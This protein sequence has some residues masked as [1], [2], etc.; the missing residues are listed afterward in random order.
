M[1]RLAVAMLMH[2]GNSFSPLVTG[3]AEFRAAVWCEGA[4]AAAA[5]RGTPSE[6]GGVLDFLSTRSDWQA[7]FLRLAHATPAGPLDA[8]LFDAICDEIVAGLAGQR[9]DAVYLALHGALMVEG[10]DLADLALIARVREAIGA[11][12]LFGVSFDLHANLDPAIVGHVDFASGYKTHPHVDQR[13]TAL[14]VL[15]ALDRTLAGEIRP[16]GHIAKA[17]TILPSINMRTDAGPMAELK[18]EAAALLG[19]AVLE[20]VPF[21][22]FSYADTAAAGAAAMVFADGDAHLAR[23]TAERLRDAIEARRDDFFQSLPDADRAIADALAAID[24]GQGPAAVVDAAD[25]PLSGGIL[26][27]PALLSALIRANP[28]V[29]SLMLLFCD[30]DLVDHAEAV[31]IGGMVAGTLGGRLS[32][33]YGAPVP[34]RATVIALSSGRFPARPPLLCGPWMDFGRLA[35]LEIEG[36]AIRV[37]VSSGS[38]SPHDPGLPEALG[39]DLTD[40]ALVCVKAKNHFRAAYDGR[41]GTIIA[42]D[43]PGP[44]A[45]DITGFAFVRAPGHLYPLSGRA[46]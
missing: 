34:I 25:N 21:G 38:A 19:G 26:D 27:T 22:G 6:I 24:A 43:A 14:R 1:A 4:E 9:F 17:D 23:R 8:G 32:A 2:E 31:G 29:P 45:L 44:A 18:A 7:E 5:Y 33:L 41:F 30:P 15:T 3:L 16:V 20:A 28:A 40:V 37:V 36:T 13:E 10:R 35:L 46:A 11:D 42:C 12:A 39:I